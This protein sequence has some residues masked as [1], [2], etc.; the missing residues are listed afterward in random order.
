MLLLN[1]NRKPYMEIPLTLSQVTLSNIER[2]KLRSLRFPSIIC[3][4]GAELAHMLLINRKACMSSLLVR[5]QL[6]LVTLKGQCQGHADF[7]GLHH[8]MEPSY[9]VLLLKANWK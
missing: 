9:T 4:K 6:T 3:R 2:S 7:E 5:L 1:V 8:L